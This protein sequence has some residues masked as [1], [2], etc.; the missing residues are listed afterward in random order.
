M[1]VNNSQIV[2]AL[3]LSGLSM[4]ATANTPEKKPVST[5]SPMSASW[6]QL[7]TEQRRDLLNAYQSLRQ[8]DDKD[9]QDLQQRMDWFSQLPKDQQQ[10]MRDAWQNMSGTEREHWKSQLKTASAEQRDLMREKIL[11]KYD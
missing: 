4:F 1:A 2:V 6:H 10:R 11:E 7:S 8:L 9:K 3:I 5:M